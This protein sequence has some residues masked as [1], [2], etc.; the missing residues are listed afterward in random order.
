MVTV[1]VAVLRMAPL[2]AVTVIV[3]GPSVAVDCALMVRVAVPLPFTVFG[4]KAAV[5][6][7]GKPLAVS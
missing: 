5:V 4:A 7:V 6:L 3:F 2:K 1:A